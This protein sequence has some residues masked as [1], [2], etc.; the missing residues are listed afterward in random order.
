MEQRAFVRHLNGIEPD[1]V[2]RVF[3]AAE[4]AGIIM[5]LSDFRFGH[6]PTVG[7]DAKL[8]TLWLTDEHACWMTMYE[9]TPEQYFPWRK[10]V[11]RMSLLQVQCLGRT[12]RGKQCGRWLPMIDT[13]Q[14]YNGAI[15]D[16]CSQHRDQYEG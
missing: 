14:K 5:S 7:L 6:R 10:H 12:V 9:T 11:D 3:Q 16:Y 15:Q 13:P 4:E 1:V 8:A 2:R